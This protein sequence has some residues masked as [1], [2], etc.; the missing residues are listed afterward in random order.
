MSLT[1]HLIHTQLLLTYPTAYLDETFNPLI[2]NRHFRLRSHLSPLSTITSLYLSSPSLHLLTNL[3]YF[4]HLSRLALGKGWSPAQL[5]PFLRQCG[6]NLVELLLAE[7]NVIFK[8]AIVPPHPHLSFRSTTTFCP[9][10]E[11]FASTDGLLKDADLPAFHN[12]TTLVLW[13]DRNASKFTNFTHIA[14]L[15][16]TPSSAGD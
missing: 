9:K 10:R 16:T 8:F 15:L 1:P 3:S 7:S 11:V 14:T 4:T 2:S 13:Q 5:Q 6:I 12:L